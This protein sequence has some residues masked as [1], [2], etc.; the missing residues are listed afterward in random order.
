MTPFRIIISFIVLAIIG[1]ALV[2]K[3][4]VDLNPREQEPVLTVSYSV[5]RS[6][7]ELVEKLATSP[8]E[9]ALS[10]LAELKKV[11]SI[12]NYN[13]GSITL[14]FDKETDM[15]FKKFE[16]ASIIRQVYPSLDQNVSYPLV[17]QSSARRTDLKTPILTYSVNG[18]FASFEIKK[19]AEDVI[20]TALNRFEEIEEVTIRGA[21]RSEERR[22]VKEC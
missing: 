4:S 10:Q 21:N 22:V 7:P 11:N 1:F 19:I 8:L 20:K 15:D 14:R 12:S 6:S 17:T 18:P 16:V 9:G 2:P 5:Q 3:L 13:V